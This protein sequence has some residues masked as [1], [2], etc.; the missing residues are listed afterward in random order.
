MAE[1]GR[2]VRVSGLPTELEDDRLK[3]K[4]LIHFLRARNGGGEIDHVTIVKPPPLSALITFEDSA[5]AQRIAQRSRHI[6]EIDGKK[7]ELDASESPGSLDPDQVV[8]SLTATVDYSRL[9]GGIKALKN[10]C[11]SHQDVHIKSIATEMCC[12]L[13]GSYYKVQAA[14]AELLGPGF[15]ESKNSGPNASSRTWSF[16]TSQ[17]P[18]ESEDQSREPTRQEEHREVK[19]DA[20]VSAKGEN[21]SSNRNHALGGDDWETVSHTDSAAQRSPTA[22]IEESSLIVDADVFQYLEN[23]CKKEYQQILSQ[24]GV[25]VVSETNQGLTTLFL[26]IADTTAVEERQE[27]MKLAKQ[28]ISRLYHENEAKICRDQL[29]KNILRPR[30][31]LQR[32]LENVSA[33]YPKLLLNEDEQNIYFIGSNKDVVDA[34]YSLLMGQEKVRNK[35]EG[36][37]SLLNFPSYNSGTSPFH[38]DEERLR[39]TTPPTEGQLNER[40]DRLQIS[41][42]DE[43]RTD[44][45]RRY[46]LAARFKDSGLSVLG[47]FPFRPNSSPSRQAHQDPILGHDVLSGSTGISGEGI[48]RAAA[49]NTGGDILFKTAH[50]S[51]SLFSP[52]KTSLTTD[53]IGTRPKNLAAPFASIP[54]SLPKSSAFPPSE[55]GSTLK[56]ASSFSG[57]PQQKAQILGQKSQ[58]DSSKPTVGV[59][60]RSS[61]FSSQTVRNKQEA[62]HEE[63]SV[64][65]VMW[66]YIKEAYSTRVED[67]TSDL[68]MK[69]NSS[70]GNRNLTVILRGADS[71]KVKLCR[72]RLQK[73]VDLVSGDFS[74][75]ELRLSELGVSSTKDETLQA[76]CSEVRSRFKKVVVHTMKENLYLV[77]P[78]ELCSQVAATLREVFSKEPEQHDFSDQFLPLNATQRRKRVPDSTYQ[79]VSTQAGIVD[80]NSESHQ[81]KTTYGRDFGEKG[82]VNGSN[83]QSS[84]KKEKVSKEKQDGNTVEKNSLNGEKERTL[85]ANQQD[86]KEH[87]PAET[88]STSEKSR[89]GLDGQICIC[90]KDKTTLV[91]T[92]CGVTL[93]PE[94]LGMSHSYCKVCNEEVEQTLQ[95][96]CGEMKKS[97]LSMSLPGQHK[98]GVIKITYH[99]PNGIQGEGHPSPGKPF[100]GAAF[101]AYLPDNENAR[102]LL[103]RLEKAFRRGLTFTVTGKGT[104][105][106]VVWGSI[107]HKTSLYGGKSEKGYPDSTYLTRLSS[108]L[109][110]YG[111]V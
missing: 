94:C 86:T 100:K 14:L 1:A 105:A 2:I 23:H 101:E 95:G 109:T 32:E 16:Q 52:I 33:R 61:S 70:E 81:W 6:L 106:K 38:S 64:S 108:I 39:Q 84:P 44:G 45:A 35:K 50:T 89:S 36:V 20:D 71:S 29:P 41:E 80:G 92:K 107:P 85:Q 27:S 99:I 13:V 26:Q 69:E 5:V 54:Y 15:S 4:L 49:Q 83:S 19:D 8:L 12:T 102:K 56:R 60:E 78:E 82:L 110:S 58:D 48:S 74:V 88:Q 30:G 10:L 42:E 47:G 59:R 53:M 51:P 17:K 68:Q 87:T 34:R 25:E 18:Q 9:P 67:L 40:I 66:Q 98:G 21:V 57:T 72:E 65:N 111:I 77:G 43:L 79:V 3:D 28:A 75:Q 91:R 7:Y 96:I 37:A 63:I 31:G 22:F 104:E 76:C 24:F 73:L 11:K 103:P 93:C 90:G 97:K 62:H 55:T 46:K